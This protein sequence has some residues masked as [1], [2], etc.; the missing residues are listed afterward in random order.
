MQ[1]RMILV[2]FVLFSQPIALADTEVP[3]ESL[4]AHGGH[5]ILL[6]QYTATWCESCATVD[7][8]ITDFVDS[9]STRVVRVALHPNDHDPFGSPLT[10][11][12]IGLKQAEHQL[13]LPTF[14][15]DGESELQGS[16]SQS[17]L[18]NELRS[19]EVRRTDWI[20]MGVWWD[21]WENS[22]HD[23]I[24]RFHLNID[25]DLPP[26]AI[27]TV[28]RLETLEM[29]SEIANN[30][31]DVHHDV[32]TQMISF[33]PNGSVLDSFDGVHGWDISKGNLYSEG[34]IP[35]YTLETYGEVDGFVTIIEDN[36]E[37]R[38]VI[39]IKTD[40]NP[41]KTEKMVNFSL[42]WLIFALAAS[43]LLLSR[44]NKQ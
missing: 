20:E 43:G 19:A 9:H 39:G 5:A 32:A 18:E 14:W 21:S 35:V 40:D 15:F 16:V 44:G 23:D 2:L 28:F 22:P 42:F 25:E 3:D 24:H 11:Y 38:S 26:D 41:R 29:T 12:R 33:S 8:W 17:L 13:Q 1:K 37:V 36:G 31:I 7:P 27:I 34:G 6:E 10:T 30:G 4:E